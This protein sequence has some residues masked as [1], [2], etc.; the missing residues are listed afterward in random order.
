MSNRLQ[1][2]DLIKIAISI[3]AVFITMNFL[4]DNIGSSAAY[5]IA[6]FVI[7]LVVFLLHS[8]RSD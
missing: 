7:A 3:V 6:V 4:K 2:F 5:M 8:K 1:M